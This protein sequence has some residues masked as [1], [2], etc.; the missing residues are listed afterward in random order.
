MRIRW[1]S[2]KSFIFGVIFSILL[3][4]SAT[5]AWA[6]LKEEGMYFSVSGVE[7]SIGGDFTGAKYY[8]YEESALRCDVPEIESDRGFGMTIGGK[9]GKLAGELSYLRSVH[10]TNFLGL[11]YDGEVELVNL[12]I[13]FYTLRILKQSIKAYF[14]TGIG[15]PKITIENAATDGQSLGDAIYKGFGL[16]LGLGT[17][18]RILPNLGIDGSVVI[19]GMRINRIEAF[20]K[21]MAPQDSFYATGRSYQVKLN[22]YF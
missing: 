8:L 19:R 1:N 13:K 3:F 15:F 22:Y 7:N 11:P 4:E 18:I 16:N 20:G 12:D 17:E 14:L 5:V 9:K 6:D 10:N 2:L 21:E